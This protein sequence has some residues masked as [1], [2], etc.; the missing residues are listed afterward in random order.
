MHSIQQRSVYSVYCTVDSVNPD[1]GCVPHSGKCTWYTQIAGVYLTVDSVPGTPKL[2]LCTPQ[3]VD[4]VPCTTTR[5]CTPHW[6][7]HLVQPDCGCLPHSG[8][9]ARSQCQPGLRCPEAFCSQVTLSH[10]TYHISHVNVT[11]QTCHM[12][13]CHVSHMTGDNYVY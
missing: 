11:C 12:L 1:C 4:S 2:R 9:R 5:V 8:L 7:V 10:I 3:C 13:H 6:K